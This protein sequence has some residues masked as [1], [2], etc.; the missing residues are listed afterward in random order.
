M[1]ASKTN[2]KSPNVL[3]S[4]R[5]NITDSDIEK[6]EKELSQ[7]PGSESVENVTVEATVDTVHSDNGADFQAADGVPLVVGSIGNGGSTAI[8]SDHPNFGS[9]SEKTR[10]VVAPKRTLRKAMN[11][12]DKHKQ[13]MRRS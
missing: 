12:I 4:K 7:V 1:V 5:E 6:N 9:A 10:K 8:S 11:S 13:R 3:G 2:S